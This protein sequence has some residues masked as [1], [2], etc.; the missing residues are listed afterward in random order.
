MQQRHRSRFACQRFKDVARN[1][2]LLLRVANVGD[3]YLELVNECKE[4]VKDFFRYGADSFLTPRMD[5]AVGTCK[6]LYMHVIRFYIGDIALDTYERFGVG[7]EMWIMQGFK[8]NNY[9]SKTIH[10]KFT[11]GRGN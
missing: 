9:E 11:D 6:K 4:L 7:V 5:G 3:N 1:L 10:K 2:S 8:R